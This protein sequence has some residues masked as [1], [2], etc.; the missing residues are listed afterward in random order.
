MDVENAVSIGPYK[1]GT[2]NAHESCQENIPDP[3]P[4]EMLQEGFLVGA[5]RGKI[6]GIENKGFDAKPPGALQR[7]GLWLIAHDQRN[8]RWEA[9]LLTGLEDRLKVSPFA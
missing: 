9:S 5:P 2:Q 6:A 8:S 1:E 7:E 3:T 4:F